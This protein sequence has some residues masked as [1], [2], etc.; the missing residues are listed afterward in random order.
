MRSKNHS[1]LNFYVLP[2]LISACLFIPIGCTSQGPT[3][4]PPE[5][6]VV[7]VESPVL[8]EL[9]SVAEFTGR[10]EPVESQIVQSQVTGYLKEIKFVDGETIQPGQVLFEIDPVPFEAALLNAKALVQKAINDR[11]S[12]KKRLNLASTDYERS[13]QV[14]RGTLSDQELDVIRTNFET[15][16]LDLASAEAALSAAQ[17]TEQKAAF[18][19]KN[20]SIANDVS[21]PGRVSRRQITQGNLVVAGQTVLCKVTSLDPVYV[22]FDV[23]EIKSL[24][25]RRKILDEK[26]LPDP[27]TKVKLECWIGLKNE[28]RNQEGKWPHAGFVDYIDP[29]IKRETGTREVRGVLANDGV[30]LNAGDSARV[31]VIDGAREKLLTIPEIAIGSQQQQKFVYIIKETDGKSVAEFRPVV[32]GP[33]RE[34]SGQRLQ[35]VKSGLTE[36]DKV[37]V[38]GLLRVR[39]GA[40]VKATEQPSPASNSR[41]SE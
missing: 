16:T 10:I 20:C 12:A 30:R 19:R 24:E 9:D 40:V 8:R 35:I 21:V 26:T 39:P 22:Y 29:E 37:V 18:D 7:T 32:L 36:S 23:D 38:N 4:A 2:I 14:A 34:I 15:S 41:T 25:Y 13:K 27:R 5:P 1:R 33:V 31:Q 17:A 28:S 11:E 6:P 3:V